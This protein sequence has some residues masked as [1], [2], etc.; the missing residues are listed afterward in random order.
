MR[1]VPII[2]FLFAI[3]VT[4]F[5]S[6]ARES[7]EPAARECL[8]EGS[9]ATLYIP[10]GTGESLDVQVGTKAEATPVD[11]ARV[12]D[13]YVMIFEPEADGGKK[14]Y[15]RYFTFQHQSANPATLDSQSSEGWYVANKS[16][17]G[18]NK[19]KPTQGFVKISTVSKEGC[20]LVVLANISNTFYNM[21]LDG[22]LDDKPQSALT[23]LSEKVNKLSDLKKVKVVLGQDVVNRNDLFLMF[24]KAEGVNTGDLRWGHMSS[25]SKPTPIYNLDSPDRIELSRLDA[26]VKFRVRINDINFSKVEPRFWQAF[27]VPKNCFLYPDETVTQ[28]DNDLF[29]ALD[30]YF[31]TTETETIEVNGVPKDVTW[32]VFTFYMLENRQLPKESVSTYTGN[33]YSSL[34]YLRDY[35]DPLPGSEY[36][37]NGETYYTLGPYKYA[38]DDATYVQFDMILTLTKPGIN[39]ID[40][41]AAEALTSDAIFT[42]HLGDFTNSESG[43]AAQFDDYNTRRNHF[44]TYDILIDNSNSIYVE[45]RGVGGNAEQRREDEPGHEGSLMLTTQGIINCDAHYEYHSMEFKYDTKLGEGGASAGYANRKKYSWYI[46]TPFGEGSGEFQNDPSNPNYGWYEIPTDGAGNPTVDYAWVKF[47]LNGI[48]PQSGEYKEARQIYPGNFAYNPDWKP[49]D[50]AYSAE[51]LARLTTE[52]QAVLAD[53][54]NVPK[55]MDINQL[56]NFLFWQNELK[57][58]NPSDTRIRFDSEDALRVTAFVDEFYYERNPLTG[59]LDPDLW[60]QFVNAIPRELHILSDAEYSRDR[61][62]DVILSSHSIVQRSIQTIYNIYAPDLTSLWGTEH[63]DEMSALSRKRKNYDDEGWPWWSGKA[64]SVLYNDDEN[65]RINSAGIWGISETGSDNPR[66]DSFLNYAKPNNVPELRD[67]KY[68]QAYSCLTRNRDNNGNGVIDPDELRWYIASINQLVGMWV[69]NEAL[70]QTARVY[71]PEDPNSTDGTE[72]GQ[73]K[74]RSVIISSTCPK[75]ITKPN[76]LRAEEGATKSTLDVNNFWTSSVA[77]QNKIIS[78]RCLRNIGTYRDHGV[79]KEITDAPFD[80]MVDQYYDCEA[81]MDKNSKAWPNPDG[82]YTIRF[83]RLNAKAIREYTEEDL[84]YHE[85]YSM[86]NRVYLHFTAQSKD[87]YVYRDGDA[88]LTK[89][90]ADLNAAISIH[91]DFCPE[92]YRLP[93]MTELLMMVALLPSDYWGNNGSNNNFYPCRSYYSRGTLGSKKTTSTKA[94]DQDKIA[95]QYAQEND[96]VHMQD[97]KNSCNGIRCIKDNNKVGDITGEISV[98]DNDNV[99]LNVPMQIN[100]NFSSM[101]S[102]ISDVKLNLVYIDAAGSRQTEPIPATGLRLGGMTLRTGDNPIIYTIDPERIPNI[103]DVYGF[104]TVQ[105]EVRNSVGIVRYFDAP[106][107]LVS[108]LY[109]SIKLLPLEYKADVTQAKFPLLVTAAHIDETVTSWQLRVTTPDKKTKILP[110]SLPTNPGGQ[111][112]N[113]ASVFYKY[114]PYADG[115]TLKQG[116]YIFQLEAIHGSP[117]VTTRSETVSMDVLKVNYSSIPKNFDWG[118]LTQASQIADYKW[119]RDMIEGLDFSAGDF[120]ETDMDISHCV[121]IP[122]PDD[123]NPDSRQ[124]VGQDNLISFGVK[125]ID[126]VDQSFHISYP[127][128]PG[129]DEKKDERWLYFAT[130]WNTASGVGRAGYESTPAPANILNTEALHIRLDKNGFYWNG[131]LLDISEWPDAKRAKVQD[132]IDRLTGAKTLYIGSVQDVH[133]SRATYRFVRVVYNG[134]YSSTRGGEDGFVHDPIHGG[135]L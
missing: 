110:V 46:K 12:H 116:T 82:T 61:R 132:V 124:S 109:T 7:F 29:D 134:R 49:G 4:F 64:P 77:N 87:N 50:D 102:V 16:I 54:G 115:G 63:E 103:E 56:I 23:V 93:N 114:D 69:G 37:E 123:E 35:R 101:A 105:A 57:Y 34:Y 2:Y 18:D 59:E 120:I 21:M 47:G 113:Y 66:W 52:Q 86:N 89:K 51:F 20:T 90:Q 24:G 38:S 10:F 15:D 126:W 1:R 62:S 107:R 41:G 83:S 100:L 19:D 42:V 128:V 121:F 5:S 98:T 14:M 133:R 111:A 92:G 84:P 75:G 125:D 112:V 119:D 68:Y 11:E 85:E 135:D 95:W 94:K 130:A 71:Q 22:D 76:L 118:S 78:T 32:Q 79:T 73:V 74:W 3:L 117:S 39:K 58:V 26:K 81:G 108:Q 104:M 13:L 80:Y 67:D 96:R 17:S 97:A 129:L 43:T 8:P 53:A 88:M 70:T 33:E 27:R 55:L 122:Y 106:I 99:K 30:T 72:D 40:P 36:V 9:P 127:A 28:D 6:C 131:H 60:R 44:Y 65:G 91:N 45:V 31:E 48:D 25:G